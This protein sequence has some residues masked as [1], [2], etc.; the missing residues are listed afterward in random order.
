MPRFGYNGLFIT[1]ATSSYVY[2]FS[3]IYLL[4]KYKAAV[5]K[6]FTNVIII[7]SMFCIGSKVSN[8]FLGCFLVI[9]LWQFTSLNKVLIVSSI[10][11]IG[12][13][14]L[15][16]TFFKFGLFNEICQK[17]GLM[18]SM[19]SYRDEILLKTL[20]LTFKNIIQY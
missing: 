9:Y 4:I 19:M 13:L 8:L 17:D 5:L 12:I 20:L 10:V 3:L 11:V 18:S 1:S 7:G 15:Y 6:K 16:V 14:G 2:C